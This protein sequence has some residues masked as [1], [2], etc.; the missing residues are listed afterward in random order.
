MNK[1]ASINNTVDIKAMPQV[2]FNIKNDVK[3]FLKNN[4]FEHVKTHSIFGKVYFWKNYE[5]N[6]NNWSGLDDFYQKLIQIQKLHAN[7]IQSN[8]LGR[9]AFDRN[10]CLKAIKPNKLNK[11]LLDEDYE[12]DGTSQTIKILFVLCDGLKEKYKAQGVYEQNR[13]ILALQINFDDLKNNINSFQNYLFD[14][15]KHEIVHFLNSLTASILEQ[16]IENLTNAALSLKNNQNLYVKN[17]KSFQ[18]SNEYV[19]E[20]RDVLSQFQHIFEQL[21][22]L[23]REFNFDVQI[24]QLFFTYLTNYSIS[25]KALIKN[26]TILKLYQIIQ[27]KIDKSQGQGYFNRFIKELNRRT[28]NNIAD[29][30]NKMLKHQNN[31]FKQQDYI[32][33]VKEI[34]DILKSQNLI[35]F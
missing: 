27:R 19:S 7:K 9:I 17:D 22:F 26:E 31:Y 10:M 35:S 15:L 16:N 12:E 32:D 11:Y 34:Y 20:I 23:H 14:V 3:N 24:D 28:N 4:K 29:V 30:K 2:Y 18:D 25:K 21:M 13:M 8:I 5:L 1:L 6:L 33:L